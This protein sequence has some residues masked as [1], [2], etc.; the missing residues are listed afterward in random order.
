LDFVDRNPGDVVPVKPPSIDNTPF[1]LVE[2]VK[3]LKELAARLR[4]VNEFSV[5]MITI[6]KVLLRN[7]L[8]NSYII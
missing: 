8:M 2:E 1:K 7:F 6:H 3:D 4:S 5:K